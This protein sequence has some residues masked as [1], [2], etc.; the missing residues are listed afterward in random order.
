MKFRNI[1]FT[2]ALWILLAG[3]GTPPIH[4]D[5]A[6]YKGDRNTLDSTASG[7]NAW[8]Q[9]PGFKIEWDIDHGRGPNEK[10]IWHYVYT[11]SGLSGRPLSEAINALY[12]ETNPTAVAGDFTF[13]S[14]ASNVNGPA[15]FTT[16]AGNIFGL[17][18]FKLDTTVLTIDFWSI[19]APAWGD[20][21]GDGASTATAYNIGFGT[22]PTASPFTNWIPTARI[23]TAVPEPCLALLLGG[24]IGGAFFRKRR[25][26]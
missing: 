24:T 13:I 21:F 18:F 4:V 16:E 7:T 10:H 25:K 23:T 1:L 14:H 6:D 8:V 15:T 3:S 20:F 17:E 12:L 9:K 26:K 19:W 11:I 22:D 5:P 2:P